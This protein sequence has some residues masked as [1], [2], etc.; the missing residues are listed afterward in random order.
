MLQGVTM[1]QVEAMPIIGLEKSSGLKP[2]GYSIA[3]AGARSGPSTRMLENGRG[4][5]PLPEA[6]GREVADNVLF[7]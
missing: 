6:D 2:T 5:D 1:L 4:G 3:R 7:I